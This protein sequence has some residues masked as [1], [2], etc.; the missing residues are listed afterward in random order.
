MAKINAVRFVPKDLIPTDEQVNIQLSN[1]K[2]AIIKANA[3]AAKTTTLAF[4]IGEA[5][6]RKLEPENIL[7][8]VFTPEAKEVLKKR[9]VDVGIPYATAAR[10][11]VATFDGFATEILEKIE[12]H[13]VPCL[14]QAKD[15]K[16]YVVAALGN[17]SSKYAGKVDFLEISTH[18]LAVSQFINAQLELKAKMALQ[19]DFEY[20]DPEEIGEQLGVQLSEYLAIVEYELIRLGHDERALFRGPFDATYDLARI[21]DAEQS[22]RHLL[23][24]Y[25]LII[26]D[27][28]HDLNEASFRILHYLI[29]PEYSYFVGAGDKDQVIHSKLGASEEYI[30]SRFKN[31]YPATASYPLTNSYRHGPHLAYAMEAFK[32]KPVD[33]KLALKT[34]INQLYYEE[35]QAA[36]ATGCA[37][38]VVKALARWRKAKHRLDQCAILI[39]DKHQSIAIENALMQADIGYRT[40]DMKGYLQREEILFLRGIVAIALGNFATVKSKKVRGDIFDAVFIFAEVVLS[41]DEKMEEFRQ[42]AVDDPEALS[43]FFSGRIKQSAAKE[44]HDKI[45]ALLDDMLVAGKSKPAEHVL[46]ELMVRVA[47]IVDYMRGADVHNVESH[48]LTEVEQQIAEMTTYLESQIMHGRADMLLQELRNRLLTVLVYLNSKVVTG[49]K[50]RMSAVVKYV[51]NLD[52]NTPADQVLREIC[53][54]IDMQ[55]LARRLYVHPYDAAVV[56]RSVQGFIAA[57]EKMQMNLR[58]FSE[59]I[60]AADEFISAGKSKSRDLVLLECVANS[61]GKEFDHVILPYLEATEFPF[62]AIASKEEENLFYVAA[63]RA[64]TCLTLISPKDESLRS[65]YIARMKINGTKARAD[66]AVEKN[67]NSAGPT[68]RIEFK[69]NGDDWAL[70]KSLGAHWDF[71]RKVFYLKEDQNPMPFAQWLRRPY[72]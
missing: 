44:V 6:A 16:D 18:S 28:L 51:E 10:V 17:V 62:A 45:K 50:N 40:G 21:L 30:N 33:S 36:E 27:E 59:W 12:Q 20:K 60:G 14:P 24:R 37:D 63:T 41:G 39:R 52:P 68:A 9:L 48:V 3:G 25:R 54:L 56:T 65:P 34:E 11:H 32:G 66:V 19:D 58:Q 42:S 23:P 49:I 5:I 22:T 57:A 43:W 55:A 53:K 1:N 2:V 7:A 69:A 47:V 8:L 64:K 26:C 61:K 15:L 46:G 29:D 72:H 38:Q 31:N 35:A 71:S 4:R 13:S 67:E 70:A